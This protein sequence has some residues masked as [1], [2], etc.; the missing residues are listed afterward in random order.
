MF[1]ILVFD[2][3]YYWIMKS[4]ADNKNMLQRDLFPRLALYTAL[5]G[6]IGFAVY[7]SLMFEGKDITLFFDYFLSIEHDSIRYRAFVLF[8][9]LLST[10]LGFFVYERE[11][12]I[13]RIQ[14]A[15]ETAQKTVDELR[16]AEEE[17]RILSGKILTAQEEERRRLTRD[18]HD[19]LGQSLLTIKLNLQMMEKRLN[20][21]EA[22][23][24]ALREVIAEV[25]S[26]IE[27]LRGVCMDIR[28]AFL[29]NAEIDEILKWCGQKFQESTG[30]EVAFNADKVSGVDPMVKDN[31]YRIFQEA[32]NNVSKHSNASTVEVTLRKSNRWLCLKVG[33]NGN[34]F[35]PSDTRNR[36]MG[37]G[38]M[39][40]RADLLGGAFKM[41]SS[42]GAGTLLSVEVPL[43]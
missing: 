32:M 28:P 1:D 10:I 5:S 31:V 40:E 18:L 8:A 20:I 37:L 19:G 30:I 9:P 17:T 35:D 6:W 11:K 27:E 43:R 23:S 41:E 36:G 3:K 21:G 22:K 25:S 42:S 7:V 14:G 39:R 13:R 26:S 34:G 12:F 4:S 29:E 24:D 16:R 15:N 2:A 38:T 33:D